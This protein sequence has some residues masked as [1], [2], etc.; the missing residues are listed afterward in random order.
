VYFQ[1]RKAALDLAAVRAI[2]AP[3]SINCSAFS[4]HAGNFFD[5]LR[6]QNLWP[7]AEKRM[8]L[9]SIFQQFKNMSD[10]QIATCRFGHCE[11]AK[12][13]AAKLRAEMTKIQ[14]FVEKT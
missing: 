3:L 8:S 7:L 6:K 14:F 1:A 5:E 12:T 9:K 11:Q 10:I 13:F 4:A 2:D